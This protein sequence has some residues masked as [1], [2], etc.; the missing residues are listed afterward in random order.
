[1]HFWLAI[2]LTIFAANAVADSLVGYVQVDRIMQQSPRTLAIGKKLQKEFSARNAVLDR[3]DKQIRD[4]QD[5]LQKNAATM[6][7]NDRLLAYRNLSN[8]KLDLE[9]K[10]REQHEDFILRKNE[11]LANLQDL[12]NKAVVS[13]AETEGYDLVL[14]DIGV[15]V[16]K[17][18]DIT[19]KVIKQLGN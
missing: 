5:A 14:Y 18:V 7:D 3:M 6:S 2:V 12:I 17:K 10:R 1:M 15:Y 11:E 16:G 8:L 9:R 19:D 4:Q 13:V